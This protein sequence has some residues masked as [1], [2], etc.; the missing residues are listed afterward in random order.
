MTAPP[1]SLL[2]VIV[3]GLSVLWNVAKFAPSFPADFEPS[4]A[5]SIQ[6][7]SKALI[8][9]LPSSNLCSPVTVQHTVSLG[10]Y[11]PSESPLFCPSPHFLL[12]RDMALV[13]WIF[14]LIGWFLVILCLVLRRRSPITIQ[15]S[16]FVQQSLPS[17]GPMTPGMRARALSGPRSPSSRLDSALR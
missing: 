8:T 6:E 17:T 14:A 7:L 9:T 12:T 15:S 1:F 4:C 5:E 13:A 3:G 2:S 10:P 16:Q 11:W